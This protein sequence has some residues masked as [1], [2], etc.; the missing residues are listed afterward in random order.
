MWT[1]S[2]LNCFRQNANGHTDNI[3]MIIIIILNWLMV[4]NRFHSGHILFRPNPSPVSEHLFGRHGAKQRKRKKSKAFPHVCGRRCNYLYYI[5][6]FGMRF[7]CTKNTYKCIFRN[8]QRFINSCVGL[9]KM[10]YLK[11][12]Y[13]S[14]VWSVD[15]EKIFSNNFSKLYGLIFLRIYP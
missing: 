9:D 11:M 12:Q 2:R 14:Q 15:D 6:Y 4:R 5:L 13:W 7:L 3:G 8:P 10:I 1:A